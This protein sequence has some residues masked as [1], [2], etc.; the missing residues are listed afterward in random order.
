[1]DQFFQYCFCTSPL[2]NRRPLTSTSQLTPPG[3]ETMKSR[4]LIEAPSES[5]LRLAS[6]T[7]TYG[8]PRLRRYSSKAAS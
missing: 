1:M 4:L 5:T 6:S 3:A 8:T 7:A 2:G